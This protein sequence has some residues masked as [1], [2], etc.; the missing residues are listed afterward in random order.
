MS[1]DSSVELNY[2]T[3]KVDFAKTKEEVSRLRAGIKAYQ[4]PVL[5]EPVPNLRGTVPHRELC[6]ELSDMYLATFE[7]IYRTVSI[8]TFRQEYTQ[9]WSNPSSAPTLFTLKLVL[10]LATATTLHPETNERHHL[11]LLSK[12][13]IYAAQWWLMGPAEKS[14]ST[15]DCIQIA[16]LLQIA[17]QMTGLGRAWATSGYLLQLA[18]SMGLH[19]D[20]DNF[21]NVSSRQGEMRRRLWAT[22]LELTLL[23]ANDTP[24][25][26]ML[27]HEEY[28]TKPPQGISDED[29]FEEVSMQSTEPSAPCSSD[30][31]LQRLLYDSFVDRV[32][33]NRLTLRTAKEQCY[34]E[35]IEVANN[36]KNACHKVAKYFSTAKYEAQDASRFH[37]SQFHHQFLDMQLRRYIL[38]LHKPFVT[39]K[40][41]DPTFYLSRTFC[42]DSALVMESYGKA[43]SNEDLDASLFNR[44]CQRT[45]GCLMGPLSLDVIT[46]LALELMSQLE[47]NP[48][49]PN[50]PEEEMSKKSRDRIFDA[51]ASIADRLRERIDAGG[52]RLKAYGLTMTIISQFRAMERGE[53]QQLAI[54]KAI[55]DHMDGLRSSLQKTLDTLSQSEIQGVTAQADFNLNTNIDFAQDFDFDMYGTFPFLAW[56][57][58]SAG[59]F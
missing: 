54:G 50:D 46:M 9:F 27:Q 22:V 7:L 11:Y 41:R 28:D 35:T 15:I 30:A 3:P 57:D 14:T 38:A 13:W 10:M 55:F 1:V 49:L 32:R 2:D 8:P 29:S 34:N 23:A 36:L 58:N 52:P 40:R 51:L 17:R 12:K 48:R 47:S 6:D 19:R 33:A 45:T 24:V 39:C 21:P 5:N 43:S 42:L 4:T 26:A 53:N 18:F 16:C 44:F 31:S 20:P 56:G 37:Y 25:P 59:V